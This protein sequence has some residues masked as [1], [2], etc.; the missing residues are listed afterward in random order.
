VEIGERDQ[1]QTGYWDLGH[2][3][4]G[5]TQNVTACC[6]QFHHNQHLRPR[7]KNPLGHVSVRR[8]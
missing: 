1:Q 2:L 8:Q 5:A 6:A 3:I 7:F 4:I